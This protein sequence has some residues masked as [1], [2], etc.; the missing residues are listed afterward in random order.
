[1]K[2]KGLRRSGDDWNVV[3]EDYAKLIIALNQS[4]TCEITKNMVVEFKYKLSK[5]EV[6]YVP[7][8]YPLLRLDHNKMVCLGTR[9]NKLRSKYYANTGSITRKKL[10][11]ARKLCGCKQLCTL[12]T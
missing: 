5:G 1:M 7:Y 10:N 9:V 2:P 4:S 3:S 8:N 12:V 11:D 6:I